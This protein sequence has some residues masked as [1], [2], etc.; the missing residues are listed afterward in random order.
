MHELS[1]MEEVRQQALQAAAAEGAA[2]ITAVRLRV[3]EL[4]GVD[5][6]ALRLAFPLVMAGTIAAGATL[7]IEPEAAEAFCQPCQAPFPPG[8]LH[9]CPR[10]GQFSAALWRGRS[11]QLVDLEVC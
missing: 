1:L 11:L 9:Q 6:D 3:G 8:A 5:A 10:C 2:R 4:A 7:I